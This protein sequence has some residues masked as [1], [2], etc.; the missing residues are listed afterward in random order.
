MKAR[1]RWA[2]LLLLLAIH[3]QTTDA[4]GVEPNREIVYKTV[5]ETI[6]RLHVFFPTDHQVIR[7]HWSRYP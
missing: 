2:A 3:T 6:L 1:Y 5:G 4:D 7:R